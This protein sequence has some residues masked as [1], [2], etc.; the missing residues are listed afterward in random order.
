M[1]YIYVL[2]LAILFPTI[3]F[4][5]QISL[6][7]TLEDSIEESSGL[8]YLNGKFITHNDSGGDAA[9]Y[10][11]DTLTGDVTRTVFISNANNTDW[12][13]I[14]MDS[15]YIYIADFGNNSGARTDLKIYRLPITAYLMA[16]NDTVSV[17]TI[18]FSYANQTD[19]TPTSFETNFDAEALISYQDSLY[20]F[21]KNWGN[22][23][24]YIYPLAK[25]PGTYSLE[26]TDSIDVQGLIT[27][28]DYNQ[29]TNTIML[30]G[31]AFLVEIKNFTTSHFLEGDIQILTAETP[32][33]ASFQVEGI[34]STPNN[35]YYLTAEASITG[36]PSLFKINFPTVSITTVPEKTSL[37]YPNPS[38]EFIQ[39]ESDDFSIAEIYD[40]NGTLQKTAFNTK[41]SI[42]DL[43]KG[44]YLLVIKNKA[45]KSISSQKMMVK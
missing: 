2:F 23:W 24:T 10:E 33:G 36:T 31:Y 19:F 25:T 16:S 22:N 30:T 11:I 6:I 29:Q 35:K 8:I 3:N 43:S 40:I 1:K 26:K 20:I 17:D 7:T 44:I 34:T 38:N 9:L 5:Q 4:A 45:G 14:C 37:I 18:N 28:A 32:L 15:T 39:I 42:E 12:E 13:D 21:S 27:G 41:I